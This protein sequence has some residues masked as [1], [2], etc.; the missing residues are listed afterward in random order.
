MSG[1]V[2]ELHEGGRALCCERG[3][4]TGGSWG[5]MVTMEN[6]EVSRLANDTASVL[7]ADG[8]LRT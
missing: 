8:H 3:V 5:L 2:L 6:C 4:Q 7:S 1:A